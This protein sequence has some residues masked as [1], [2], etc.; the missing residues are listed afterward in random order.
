MPKDDELLEWLLRADPAASL[1]PMSSDAVDALLTSITG[2]EHL[3]TIRPITSARQIRY[4]IASLGA[5]SA[6]L[7]AGGGAAFAMA[8]SEL[9]T[10]GSV[11]MVAADHAHTG[12]HDLTAMTAP[13]T[14][15]L[16]SP[17]DPSLMASGGEG[18]VKSLSST[19][20]VNLGG[21]RPGVHV[22]VVSTSAGGRF[23]LVVLP[24]VA[25]TRDHHELGVLCAHYP[26]ATVALAAVAHQ[27]LQ[28]FSVHA[29]AQHSS[30][31]ESVATAALTNATSGS[32]VSITV[33]TV[34]GSI[35]SITGRSTN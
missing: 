5:A 27:G 30:A 1:A 8:G 33:T 29:L 13:T 4:R 6:V 17:R 9:A 2:D 28:G 22:Q 19:V 3:A 31:M 26:S 20:V 12:L 21:P 23:S 18:L 7:L 34:G 32:T 15:K 10:S 24:A 14:L 25:C 16:T 11:A 35:T